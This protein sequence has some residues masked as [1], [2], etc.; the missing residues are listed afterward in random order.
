MMEKYECVCG[1]NFEVRKDGTAVSFFGFEVFYNDSWGCLTDPKHENSAIFFPGLDLMGLVEE[2]VEIVENLV[3]ENDSEGIVKLSPTTAISLFLG[4]VI[5]VD[6][7]EICKETSNSIVT[8]LEFDDFLCYAIIE[9]GIRGCS[10]Q[11]L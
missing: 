10:I 3:K 1:K 7:L 9:D 8:T 6:S 4:G 2:T 11:T 5:T